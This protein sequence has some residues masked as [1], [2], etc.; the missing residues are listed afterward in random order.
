MHYSVQFNKVTGF[1]LVE[2]T[3]EVVQLRRFCVGLLDLSTMYIS[4]RYRLGHDLFGAFVRRPDF[5]CKE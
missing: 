4:D 5:C 3:G 2:M 1:S